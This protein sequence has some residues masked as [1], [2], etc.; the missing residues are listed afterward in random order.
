MCVWLFGCPQ[1]SKS[2]VCRALPTAYRLY[3]HSVYDVQRHC[4]C[5]CPSWC[6]ISVIPLPLPIYLFVL[7]TTKAS[8]R[9]LASLYLD[10][11]AWTGFLHCSA[12]LL[13]W[14]S[15]VGWNQFFARSMSTIL[16]YCHL[17]DYT[18][19][20]CIINLRNELNWMLLMLQMLTACSRHTVLQ[21]L[22]EHPVGRYS[23]CIS[24]NYDK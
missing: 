7:Q 15:T 9:P 10:L 17:S 20:M 21:C 4:S 6:Y 18:I 23:A 2:R 22:K 11:S 5:S 24:I 19:R 13:Q 3:A 12:I 14:N 16:L 1:G 8:C